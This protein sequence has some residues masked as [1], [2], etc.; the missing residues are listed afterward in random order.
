VARFAA[1]TAPLVVTL[2]L[3]PVRSSLQLSGV[4]LCDLLLVVGVALLGGIRPA[5]LATAVSFI[6]SDFFYAPPFYRLRVG[7]TVDVIALVTFVVVAAAVGGLVDVLTRRAFRVARVSAEGDN[8][9]RLAAQTLI[10]DDDTNQILAALRRTFD[11]DAATILTRGDTGWTD[12]AAP[13][14]PLVF[15]G[16]DGWPRAWRQA[17]C[18]WCACWWGRVRRRPRE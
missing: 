9:A 3:I 13:P 17:W 4:L 15:I 2:A 18:S 16:C 14:G 11:L 6:A 10:G 8:P 12:E 1:V 7:Q 5:V